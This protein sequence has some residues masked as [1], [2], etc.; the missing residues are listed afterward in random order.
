MRLPKRDI[1]ATGV[2][3]IAGLLY[4]LWVAD[5]APW[6]MSSVRMTGVAILA[7]GFVASASAVVPGFEELIRGNRVY[8]AVTSLIGLAAF[9]GG[10]WMLVAS[11]EIALGLLVGT[12]GGLW[13][14]S[15]VHHILLTRAVHEETPMV[16]TPD[17]TPT[18]RE[19]AA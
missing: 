4:A 2:V 3:A 8:L 18:E 19:E 11:S 17:I 6:G 7:L 12:M 14:I 10:L 1:V 16:T 9:A 15:T 5:L 13:L